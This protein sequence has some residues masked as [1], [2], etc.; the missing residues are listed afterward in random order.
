M[1]DMVLYVVKGDKES[2]KAIKMLIKRGVKFQ[3]IIVGKEG[4]GKSM[5]RDIRTTKIPVLHSS[6]GTFIGID[7]IGKFCKK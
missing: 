1:T 3:K 5:W 6:K 7:E 4:N 2:E